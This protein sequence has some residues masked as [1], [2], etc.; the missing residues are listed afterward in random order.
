MQG[1]PKMSRPVLPATLRNPRSPSARHTLVRNQN[2]VRAGFSI[3]L[4]NTTLLEQVNRF[5]LSLNVQ[6]R[7]LLDVLAAGQPALGL[8]IQL[9]L[10]LARKRLLCSPQSL[11]ASPATPTHLPVPW[12]RTRPQHRSCRPS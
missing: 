8:D 10:L 6:L 5:D 11:E 2:S 7:L 4:G 12:S 9:E 1:I 3:H